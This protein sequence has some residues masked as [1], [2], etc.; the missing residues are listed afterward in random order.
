MLPPH[1]PGGPKSHPRAP[2]PCPP[3]I[4]GGG[5]VCVPKAIQGSPDTPPSSRGLSNITW[6]VPSAPHH[7]WGPKRYS[8]VPPSVP[9]SPSL[10]PP[11]WDPPRITHSGYWGVTKVL[12]STGTRP[13]AVGGREGGV[14]LWTAPPFPF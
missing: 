4:L 10:P 9:L 14:T 5:G 12:G 7:P 3:F 1:H 6:G 13:A 2:P 11:P 8:R